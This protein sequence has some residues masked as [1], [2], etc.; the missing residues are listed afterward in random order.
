MNCQP[1]ILSTS[2]EPLK[3]CCFCFVFKKLQAEGEELWNSL[4]LNK[5][6]ENLSR[7]FSP[8]EG[9]FLK[10]HWFIKIFWLIFHFFMQ[11]F[12]VYIEPIFH[13]LNV[14]PSSLTDIFYALPLYVW[15]TQLFSFIYNPRVGRTKLSIFFLSGR[16]KK[17]KRETITPT[18]E[19]FPSVCKRS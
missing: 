13:P 7:Q 6:R 4:V 8:P 3:K 16:V 12:D 15:V 17:I 5:M 10:I 19:N 2:L 9:T 14:F 1:S 18:S 11:A